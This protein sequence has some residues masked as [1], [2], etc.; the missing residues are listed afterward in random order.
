MEPKEPGILWRDGVYFCSAD[1]F[2][3]ENL[4]YILWGAVYSLDKPYC[5]NRNYMDAFMLQYIVSGE[6]NFELR[7][8][9]FIAR[10]NEVVLLSCQEKNLYWAEKP[11]IVKWFHFHGKSVA[12]LLEY[13]IEK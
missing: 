3:K 1:H 2:A 7:G 9:H 6:L 5:V 8:K 11:A 12:P 10:A 13:I 4:F